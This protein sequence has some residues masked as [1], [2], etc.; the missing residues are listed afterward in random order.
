MRDDP[1][2]FASRRSNHS[3]QET[4]CDHMTDLDRNLVITGFM[5]TGKSGV[6]RIVADRLGRELRI[7][8]VLPAGAYG[9]NPVDH[10]ARL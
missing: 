1:L 6:G 2:R 5:G 8:R 3:K 10:I 9:I 7:R 4:D